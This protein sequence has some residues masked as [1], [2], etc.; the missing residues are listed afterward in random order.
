M[1]VRSQLVLGHSKEHGRPFDLEP[2]DIGIPEDEDDRIGSRSRGGRVPI[3]EAPAIPSADRSEFPWEPR[4]AGPLEGG[5]GS[6]AGQ[7]RFRL[8]AIDGDPG[9]VQRDERAHEQVGGQAEAGEGEGHQRDSVAPQ[10]GTAREDGQGEEKEPSPTRRRAS[11]R[12]S[13]GGTRPRGAG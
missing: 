6:A 2:F 5:A 9:G 7:A 4:L 1:A 10:S 13:E 3:V 11:S 8:G 12:E